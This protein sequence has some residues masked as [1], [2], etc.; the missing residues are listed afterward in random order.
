MKPATTESVLE[1]P[2]EF[3]V[4]AMGKADADFDAL[5]VSIIR[6][7]VPGFNDAT[8]RSRLSRGGKYLSVTVTIKA[9]SQEQLD[10]LYT[11]L[12]GNER[13]LVAL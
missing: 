3:P 9:Q 5:V 8:V 2:C 13:I 7:H 4:K 1:F 6:K 10:N 11:E 12:S